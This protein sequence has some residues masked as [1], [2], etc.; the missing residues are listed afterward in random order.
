MKTPDNESTTIQQAYEDA[1]K[2]V[3]KEQ[4]TSIE[5]TNEKKLSSSSDEN[6][7]KHNT[8][9][10]GAVIQGSAI[11]LGTTA[12]LLMGLKGEENTECLAVDEGKEPEGLNLEAVLDNRV[13]LPENPINDEMTFEEAFSTARELH[14]PGSAFEWHGNVYA[15]YT[16]E[17]WKEMSVQQKSD[18]YDSLHIAYP[19]RETTENDLLAQQVTETVENGTNEDIVFAEISDLEENN[20]SD[21]SK[22]EEVISG[23]VVGMPAEDPYGED[24]PV[25]SVSNSEDGDNDIQILGVTQDHSTGYNVGHLNVDGEDVFVIDVDGDM[26]FD[27]LAADVNHDGDIMP[28]EIIDISQDSISLDSL[29]GT[30][31]LNNN[32]LASNEEVPDYLS[33]ILD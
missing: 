17:E 28:D 20:A 2:I 8:A 14:G 9:K 31:D 21:S 24:I 11:L 18:F 32:S 13:T 23:Q 4:Y 33:E 3:D 6:D 10:K 25:V 1:T 27:A 15:T 30:F 22:T 19:Y 26:V 16:Q 5:E 29:G 7:T 12:S